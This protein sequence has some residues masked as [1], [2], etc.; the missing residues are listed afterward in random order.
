M[1]AKDQH[2][3]TITRVFDDA[4]AEFDR[5][6][7]DFFTPLG[8][9]LTK[10]AG[11]ARGDRVLDV[12]CGMGSSLIPA[13]E[14]VGPA[15]FVTG[16]DLSPAMVRRLNG[17]LAEH[18]MTNARATTMNG[19]RPDFPERSFEVV[20][21]GF[22]V[23]HFSSAPDCLGRYPRLLVPGGR[24]CY[25]ELVDEDGLPDLVPRDAFAELAPF[26]PTDL[27][28]PRERGII[29]WNQT[30]ESTSEALRERGFTRVTVTEHES[31]VELGSGD[32]WN[33]W[34]MSTGLR[35][36]WVNV[37]AHEVAAVRARTAAVIEQRRDA[38]GRLVLPVRVRY[39]LCETGQ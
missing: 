2:T 39:V 37:P 14:R 36:A 19:E 4:A 34:T 9:Q 33:A 28:N 6:G 31:E 12:G 30:P 32:R 23:M 7:V 10:L 20:Q 25:S 8:M 13:A 24:F 15:G 18:G 38:Q 1:S 35:Q 21:A 22:S 29:T 11:A 16:I 26:F 17:L 5:S 3:Q 27:P